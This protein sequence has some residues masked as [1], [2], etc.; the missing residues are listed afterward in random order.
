MDL[1][2]GQHKRLLDDRALLDHGALADHG[3]PD[4]RRTRV[5]LGTLAEGVVVF[6]TVAELEARVGRAEPESWRSRV[7]REPRA[8]G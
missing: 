6:G 3:R 1:G 5:H 8:S 4:D 2:L 7:V